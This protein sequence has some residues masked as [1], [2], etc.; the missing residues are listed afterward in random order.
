[1]LSLA[2]RKSTTHTGDD[3]HGRALP[4]SIGAEQSEYLSFFDGETQLIHRQKSPLK[5]RS[6]ELFG[7][8]LQNQR[9]RRGIGRF[10]FRLQDF[11]IY[12]GR[13]RYDI[14]VGLVWRQLL[15]VFGACRVPRIRRGVRSAAFASAASCAST[16]MKSF[17]ERKSEN[18]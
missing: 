9:L 15:F 16:S 4:G 6:G 1:M 5:G 14:L 7:N 13:F 11:R 18:E 12:P 3:V 17:D 8:S 10:R 2:H